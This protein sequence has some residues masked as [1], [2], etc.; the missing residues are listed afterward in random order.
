MTNHSIQS[1]LFTLR[2]ARCHESHDPIAEQA[3]PPLFIILLN[4]NA[5]RVDSV[6]VVALISTWIFISPSE[7]MQAIMISN[8]A[9]L[10][11]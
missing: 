11:Y 8:L 4:L 7:P 1:L 5:Q 9:F 10:P 6:P 3:G 2:N